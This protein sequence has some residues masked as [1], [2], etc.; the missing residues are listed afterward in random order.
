[1][2]KQILIGEAKGSVFL[3]MAKAGTTK[4]KRFQLDGA[5]EATVHASIEAAQHVVEQS[6]GFPG[7]EWIPPPKQ[8]ADLVALSRELIHRASQ[9]D[10]KP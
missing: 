3:I 2:T 10:L 7:I 6:L 1:V 8:Y 5:S 9:A 4:L